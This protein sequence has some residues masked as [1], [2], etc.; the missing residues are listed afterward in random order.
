MESDPGGD[1]ICV[2]WE[3]I[4]ICDSDEVGFV[5]RLD[6]SETEQWQK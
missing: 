1:A 6:A 2:F 3:K 4:D 5:D